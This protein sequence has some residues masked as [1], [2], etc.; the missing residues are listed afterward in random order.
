MICFFHKVSIQYFLFRTKLWTEIKK[1]GVYRYTV[2]VFI[3]EQQVLGRKDELD[4]KKAWRGGKTI[5]IVYSPLQALLRVSRRAMN[6]LIEPF[7]SW[8]A[9]C[10]MMEP[11]YCSWH[12]VILV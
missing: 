2:S 11:T 4:I 5:D 10:L 7:W 8:E 3:K 9:T 12:G 6:V 1:R